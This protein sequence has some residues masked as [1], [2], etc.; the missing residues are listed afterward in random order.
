MYG[1]LRTLLSKFLLQVCHNWYQSWLFTCTRGEGSW[2]FETAWK[3]LKFEKVYYPCILQTKKRYVG[4]MY[5]TR[6]QVKPKY[7]AK[8]IETVRRDGV[9]AVVK[10]RLTLYWYLGTV[11]PKNMEIVRKFHKIAPNRLIFRQYFLLMS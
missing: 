11:N 5:E 2:K 7:D 10:V 1:I 8:G 9:P 4:Y 6:D 3:N